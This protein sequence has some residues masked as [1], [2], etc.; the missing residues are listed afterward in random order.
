MDAFNDWNS[1]DERINQFAAEGGV[2]EEEFLNMIGATSKADVGRMWAG[3]TLGTENEN[4]TTSV[5][6]N[7]GFY[8]GRYE[9]GNDSGTLVSKAN[10]AVYNNVTRDQAKTLADG[11]YSGVSHLLTDSAWDRTLGFL[12]N[13]NNKTLS[14]VAGDSKDWGN[15]SDSSIS[16]TGSLAN[17]AAF[18]TDT[19]ANNIYD[20]AGNVWEWTSTTSPNSEIPCVRRRRSLQL[21]R[22]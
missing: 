10:V 19:R 16:G 22:F 3:F 5:N 9:A 21:Y 11:K 13:T 1:T 15:Y 14:Q 6:T 20:L 18:G 8:V 17:T 4:Y 12:I 2:S 7:G